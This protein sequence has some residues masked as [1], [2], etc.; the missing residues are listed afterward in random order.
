M[1]ISRDMFQNLLKCEKY[2]PY[3]LFENMKV[4]INMKAL[5]KTHY[6][7]LN[8]DSVDG[9][10]LCQKLN[11]HKADLVPVEIEGEPHDRK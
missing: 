9:L 3:L 10:I 6:L 4:F 2:A 5:P 1:K 7:D 8:G 11:E